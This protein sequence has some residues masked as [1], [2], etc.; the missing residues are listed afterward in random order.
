VFGAVKGANEQLIQSAVSARRQ[1]LDAV[2]K[3]LAS[4][5]ANVHLNPFNEPLVA[6]E[7]TAGAQP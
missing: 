6:V 4:T 1:K 7:I 2:L 3:E 5:T